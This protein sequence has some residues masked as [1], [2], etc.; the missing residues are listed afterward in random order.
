MDGRN[1]KINAKIREHSLQHVPIIAVVGRKEAEE[2]TVTLRYLGQQQQHTLSLQAAIED[3][4]HQGFAPRY[5]TA[6]QGVT[7]RALPNRLND[8]RRDR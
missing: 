4:C 7:K 3:P 2:R 8:H 5:C 1:E 6:C